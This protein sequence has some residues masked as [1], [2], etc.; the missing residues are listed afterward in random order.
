MSESSGKKPLKILQV[1]SG[2]PGWGGTELHLINLAEQLTRRGHQ[3]L[4]AARPGKFVEQEA[5]K[6]NLPT[7]PLT[8]QRQMDFGDSGKFRDL[9]RREQFD[10][11]HVHWSTDYIVG[12]WVA[13]QVGVPAVLMSRHS[14]YPLKSLMGRY[15]YNRVLFDRIIALS[16]SVRQTLLG[17]GLDADKVVTIHHGTDTEAFRATTKPA[18]QV[19]Q[20]WGIPDEAF[21]VGLAGRIAEE[22]GWRVLIEALTLPAVAQ[23]GVRAVLI[24]DGPEG[25][26]ARQMVQ[27]RG[28]S[29]R[30]TFAGF[31]SDIN[32]AI[33]AVDV[34]VLTSTWAEP[35]AAVVQQAMALGKPVIGTNIG[36]TPEMVA[37]KETGVLVVSGDAGALGEAIVG[38]SEDESLRVR[39]GK[40]GQVR[41]EERFTLR[42][43][44]D[45]NE[46]LYYTILQSKGKVAIPHAETV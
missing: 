25:E 19:R 12:P 24:G 4:V 44:T 22:K 21:V 23:R 38:L 36:G 34:L 1:G 41:V 39:M 28:L 27:E 46:Q 2:F 10:V 35:C 9:M 30:V 32:N 6:R 31:R 15:L 43:M 16:E 3:V 29:S 40:A 37:D 5:Q 7:V 20:E 14:P 13:K 26:L 17:Q 33:G 18:A 42:G 45:K 11:V 8:V